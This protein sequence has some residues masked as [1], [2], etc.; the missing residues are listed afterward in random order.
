M[1]EARRGRDT[2]T[3]V[4]F[5]IKGVKW[6]RGRKK[7]KKEGR[8]EEVGEGR[9]YSVEIGERREGRD[10]EVHGKGVKWSRLELREGREGERRG[11][12]DRGERD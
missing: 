3:K 12:E 2:Y 6:E 1:K 10:D 8:E 9:K 5:L 11:G 4:V 7:K